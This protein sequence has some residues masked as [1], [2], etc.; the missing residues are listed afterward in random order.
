MLLNHKLVGAGIVIFLSKHLKEV[1]F[2]FQTKLLN[3]AGKKVLPKLKDLK[4]VIKWA[5][6]LLHI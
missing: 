5:I 2:I 4:I 6:M 1:L 3:S